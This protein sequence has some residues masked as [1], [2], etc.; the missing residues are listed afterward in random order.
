VGTW[1]DTRFKQEDSFFFDS[2]TI[3]PD[4]S[5]VANSSAMG[6]F[7]AVSETIAAFSSSASSSNCAGSS[8]QREQLCGGEPQV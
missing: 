2:D 8:P 5:S 1:S 3:F 7:H 4:G 6:G